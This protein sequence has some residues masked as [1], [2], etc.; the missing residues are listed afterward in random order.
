MDWL[1]FRKLS[2]RNVDL[3]ADGQIFVKNFLACV[4]ARKHRTQE[5]EKRQCEKLRLKKTINIEGERL[6]N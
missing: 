4:R 2:C 1:I 6:F 5:A 3:V